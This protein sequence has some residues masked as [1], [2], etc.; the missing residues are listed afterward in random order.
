MTTVRGEGPRICAHIVDVP[1]GPFTI[2]R[3]YIDEYGQLL[4]ATRPFI[5]S[6]IALHNKNLEG[7]EAAGGYVGYVDQ[8]LCEVELGVDIV[9]TAGAGQAGQDGGGLATARVTDEQGVLAIMERSA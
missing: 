6:L 8:Q 7:Q 3:R 9:A 2:E 5:D 4:D 1:V